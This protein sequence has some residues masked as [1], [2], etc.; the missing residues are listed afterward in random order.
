[1]KSNF[2]CPR[3]TLGPKFIY[4]QRWWN[5]EYVCASSNHISKIIGV[6]NCGEGFAGEQFE[7][8]ASQQTQARAPS[9]KPLPPSPDEVFVQDL[10]KK[11]Q[12]ALDTAK[13]LSSNEKYRACL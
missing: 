4:S 3:A 12:S 2:F 13:M 11:R 7:T 6:Q 1:M 8:S 9:S 10:T 5:F